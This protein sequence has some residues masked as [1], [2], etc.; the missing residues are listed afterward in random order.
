VVWRMVR[1]H[2]SES[3][4]LLAALNDAD[5]ASSADAADTN[6]CQPEP[7]GRRAGNA[8]R[9]RV[10]GSDAGA[11]DAARVEKAI[12]SGRLSVADAVE[13]V[14]EAVSPERI[15]ELKWAELVDATLQMCQVF[16]AH[17]DSRWVASVADRV[18][19]RLESEARNKSLLNAARPTVRQ[20][21]SLLWALGDKGKHAAADKGWATVVGRYWHGAVQQSAAT[22][23]EFLT[24]NEI[25]LALQRVEGVP[26]MSD[27]VSSV[28]TQLVSSLR[29]V[30]SGAICPTTQ[31]DLV[32][33][34][35]LRTKVMRTASLAS[36]GVRAEVNEAVARRVREAPWPEIVKVCV[37]VSCVCVCVYVCARARACVCVCVCARVRVRARPA[38]I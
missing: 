6:A 19:Q 38:C 37:C 30:A 4:A 25:V 36:T 29:A 27:V 33:L 10:R 35:G 20:L 12:G 2:T 22:P 5:S 23:N 8:K 13:A 9:Q 11:S 1:E 14:R 17:T 24:T 16:M 26:G 31:H 15:I 3:H 21:S 18:L 34:V 7:T 32:S 28:A